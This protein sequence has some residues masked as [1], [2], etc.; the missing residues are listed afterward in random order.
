M[1]EEIDGANVV[2]IDSC[3]ETI[4]HA[5]ISQL[6]TSGIGSL[7]FAVGDVNALPF[8]DNSFNLILAA[9]CL[10][11]FENYEH[12]LTEIYRVTAPSGRIILRNFD[13]GLISVN[14]SHS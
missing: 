3:A 12:A 2:G 14:P 1:S 11:Y 5:R 8:D 7:R 4:D 10:P 13:D 6:P 9:N